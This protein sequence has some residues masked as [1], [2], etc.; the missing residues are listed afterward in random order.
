[1]VASSYT[2]FTWRNFDCCRFEGLEHLEEEK[3]AEAQQAGDSSDSDIDVLLSSDLISTTCGA[4]LVED[5]WAVSAAHCFDDFASEFTEETRRVRVV[6]I[7]VNATNTLVV[8]IKMVYTHPF[9]KYPHTNNDVAVL[10]LGRR[11]EYDLH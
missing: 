8:D 4:T 5:Q 2:D 1:M 9:Y 3:A 10:E 7:C 11:I 6:T